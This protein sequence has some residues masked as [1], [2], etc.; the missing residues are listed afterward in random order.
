MSGAKSARTHDHSQH[1]TD[2]RQ[3]DPLH[4]LI[5]IVTITVYAAIFVS[6]A[7]FGRPQKKS[8]WLGFSLCRAAFCR[9]IVS[10]RS[11]SLSSRRARGLPVELKQRVV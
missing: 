1:L 3:R 5:N 8:V 11:S 10:M 4:S 6:I 2:P 7:K 9:M